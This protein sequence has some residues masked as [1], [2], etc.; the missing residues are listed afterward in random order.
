M[1]P[2]AKPKKEL[3]GKHVLLIVIAIFG[4]VFAVNG[5]MVMQ[6]VKTFRGEDTKQSYRQG[7]AY[8]ET[9][10]MRAQQKALGWRAKIDLNARIISLAIEDKSGMPVRGLTVTGLLKHPTKP[11]E[12]IALVNK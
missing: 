9:L 10:D 7:L 4:V 1:S 5:F 6:A 8:N 11:S 3:T 12:R 2:S